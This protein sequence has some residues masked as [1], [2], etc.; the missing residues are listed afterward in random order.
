[1]VS[2]STY[3][4]TWATELRLEQARIIKVANMSAGQTVVRALPILA[5]GFLPAAEPA[6]VAPSPAGSLAGPVKTRETACEGCRRTLAAHQDARPDSRVDSGIAKAVER[7]TRAMRELSGR[8]F[9]APEA[10]PDDRPAPVEVGPC[11]AS[12]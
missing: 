10:A 4:P 5:P 3:K 12:P 1:M 8:A 11:P 6:D 2:A 7:Q 9:P